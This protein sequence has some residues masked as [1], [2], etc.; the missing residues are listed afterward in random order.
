MY[1]KQSEVLPIVSHGGYNIVEMWHGPSGSLKD[2]SLGLVTRFLDY[3]TKKRKIKAVGVV[4]TLGDT[5]CAAIQSCLGRDNIKLVVLYPE[6]GISKIQRL[7]MTTVQS[8][9]I[10]VYGCECGS[11]EFDDDIK[12][13][14]SDEQFTT[15]H[16]L[17]WLNSVNIGRVLSHVI[18]HVYIY[19]KLCPK[20][21]K[22]LTIYVPTGAAGNAAGACMAHRM[23]VPIKIVTAVNEND[24]LHKC[25]EEGFLQQPPPVIKTYACAIDSVS[26]VNIERILY[27]L[28]GEDGELIK[29]IMEGCEAGRTVVVPKTLRPNHVIR[30]VRVNQHL[31]LETARTLWKDH[32]YM[33]CP[34]TSVAI[35]AAM[36]EQQESVNTE[37][38]ICY[39]TATPA[40]FHAFVKAVDVNAPQPKHMLTEGLEDLPENKQVM[41]EKENWEEILKR[42]IVE[43]YNM[44]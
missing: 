15:R 8:P 14:F 29:D 25:F 22:E 35:A 26:L 34:H 41:K 18:F 17:L 3:F 27:L 30:S 1:S 33:I 7:S 32:Q 23:G 10:R 19:L 31:A 43:L 21:D 42:Q 24:N 20:V 39:S 44:D 38:A 11:D 37:M 13:V 5:G 36:I 28:S 16:H 6:N 40:K 2:F 9:N 4:G 12:K